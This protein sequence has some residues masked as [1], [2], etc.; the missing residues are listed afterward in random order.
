[1]PVQTSYPG[2]YVEERPSG[3]HTIV[4]GSTSV[5]AFVGAARMGPVGRPVRINSAAEY[6]RVF[7]G[8]VDATQPMGH[9]V[10]HF[11]ANGGTRA[12]VVRVVG[13]GGTAAAPATVTLKAGA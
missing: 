6:G 11:F 2:V 10:T 8:P 9:A 1:M 4:G 5:T 7:G 13:A 12:I 3:V